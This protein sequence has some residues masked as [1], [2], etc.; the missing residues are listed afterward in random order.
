LIGKGLV[1]PQES[2]LIIAAQIFAIV[3]MLPGAV[4]K[5]ASIREDSFFDGLLDHPHY[6]RPPE[7]EGVAIPEVL[8]SGHHE[9]IRRWRKRE[10]LAHAAFSPRFVGESRVGQRGASDPRGVA[11]RL[12]AVE[13][14][15]RSFSVGDDGLSRG[16]P[17]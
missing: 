4:G 10:A 17:G 3:R 8:Q 7:L 15:T 1:L 12:I 6:T 13:V 9:E 14:C 16:N 2:G 11:E 5:E